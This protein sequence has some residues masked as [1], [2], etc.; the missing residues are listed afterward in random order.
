MIRSLHPSTAGR[1]PSHSRC[2]GETGTGLFALSA[3]VL[4]FLGFL[5]FAVQLLIGL[6]ARTSVHSAAFD[7]AR[8]VATAPIDHR[9]SNQVRAAEG[10]AE[11]RVRKMLGQMGHDA[12]IDWSGTTAD[13][14]ALRVQVE[15]PRFLLPGLSSSIG[16]GHL[17]HTARVHV[18][19]VR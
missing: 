13:A 18:E 12:T 14:V 17:D 6:H 15:P 3:G 16:S 2:R 19:Q 10:R 4:V 7:G 9:D 1:R 11:E 5:L 8:M